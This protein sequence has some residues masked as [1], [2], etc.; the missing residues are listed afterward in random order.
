MEMLS[1]FKDTVE[2][3]L[4]EHDMPASRLGTLAVKDPNFVSDLR[5][6]RR[7]NLALADKVLAF[8]REQEAARRGAE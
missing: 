4:A 8:I 6:G 3:F 1:T 5:D 2:R 7:P